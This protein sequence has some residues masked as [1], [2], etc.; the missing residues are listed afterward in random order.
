MQKKKIIPLA[1]LVTILGCAFIFK[2]R[3]FK[4]QPVPS[5]PSAELPILK[6]FIRIDKTENGRVDF[7]VML[8]AKND[9]DVTGL[10]AF[11]Y[12]KKMKVEK[13]ASGKNKRTR[14]NSKEIGNFD[15]SEGRIELKAGQKLE[16]PAYF[17]LDKLKDT[18]YIEIT[19]AADVP[20]PP[21]MDITACVEKQMAD[22]EKDPK[23]REIYLLE[24]VLKEE[25]K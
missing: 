4:G 8:E 10:R 17:V 3:I 12:D 22:M 14:L 25:T 16:V 15:L 2:D 1:F 13:N 9:C 6:S 19:G 23:T 11:Y 5:V 24:K 20:C 7:T 21:D 18:H